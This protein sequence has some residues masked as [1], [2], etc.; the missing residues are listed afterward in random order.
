[1]KFKDKWASTDRYF[2][3]NYHT[4]SGTQLMSQLG[5]EKKALTSHFF[6]NY[7]IPATNSQERPF[8][9]ISRQRRNR[10]SMHL[11]NN[12]LKLNRT[13]QR[14]QKKKLK[15]NIALHNL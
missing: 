6:L 11:G 5:R 7:K 10:T 14:A 1:M 12:P 3:D 8:T 15:D 13:L 9:N 4:R 2:T